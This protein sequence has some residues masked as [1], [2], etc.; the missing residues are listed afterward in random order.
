M[1]N[2]EV[3]SFVTEKISKKL[4]PDEQIMWCGTTAKGATPKE[5]GRSVIE[6]VFAAVW[7]IIITMGFKRMFSMPAGMPEDVHIVGVADE[8]TSIGDEKV[9][10]FMIVFI[11]L[12]YLAGL[13]M[14]FNFFIPKKLYY[15]VTDRRLYVL[16]KSG[17]IV[18]S[19]SL[20]NF[21]SAIYKASDRGIGVIRLKRIYSSDNSRY[22]SIGG[23]ADCEAV[24]GV[25]NAAI[26]AAP[27]FNDRR[28]DFNIF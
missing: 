20:R 1:N 22:L 28:A 25:F 10:I 11:A 2:Y 16:K 8:V 26:A 6:L 13:S 17:R 7:F 3:E 14:V 19:K 23:I 18:R 27:Q 21:S 15:A 9:Q 4:V 5:R 12:F 24:C